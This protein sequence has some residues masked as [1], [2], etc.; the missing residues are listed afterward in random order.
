MTLPIRSSL[1]KYEKYGNFYSAVYVRHPSDPLVVESVWR[2][3]AY[4]G[5]P[6]VQYS[7]ALFLGLI[8][9]CATRNTTNPWRILAG[10]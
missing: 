9:L 5:H 2:F 6:I 3:N 10:R 7:L 4:F 1:Q 8:T